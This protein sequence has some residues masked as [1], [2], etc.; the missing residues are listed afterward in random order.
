MNKK[1]LIIEIRETVGGNLAESRRI[2]EI[3]LAALAKGF[4]NGRDITIQGFGTFSIWHQSERQGR[5]PQNGVPAKIQARTSIK[6]KPGKEL[7]Y[8]LNKNELSL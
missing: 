7:L 5:N 8:R 4:E 1:D 3:V 6:F 2:L